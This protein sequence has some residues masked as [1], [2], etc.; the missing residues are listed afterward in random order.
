MPEE[1]DY[2]VT[3]EEANKVSRKILSILRKSGLEVDDVNELPRMGIQFTFRLGDPS[4]HQLRAIVTRIKDASF[5]SGL[6]MTKPWV[7]VR[8][9]TRELDGQPITGITVHEDGLAAATMTAAPG[10]AVDKY[11]LKGRLTN[12]SHVPDRLE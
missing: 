5:N 3:K 7:V 8:I 2:G 9:D 4:I 10:S 6:S 11:L 12:H 1:P